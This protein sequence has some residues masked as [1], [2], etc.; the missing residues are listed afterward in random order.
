MVLNAGTQGI[1]EQPRAV[2]GGVEDRRHAA[3]RCVDLG[4]I[5]ILQVVVRGARLEHVDAVLR[6]SVHQAV[7]AAHQVLQEDPRRHAERFA[8][9]P[10]VAV[11]R[12]PA[13]IRG[14]ARGQR[15]R[16]PFDRRGRHQ[17]VQRERV[18]RLLE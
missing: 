1:S 18:V 2:D 7:A 6:G 10:Y 13:V 9:H 5:T 16:V 17:L 4:G 3:G 8:R 11:G 14:V 12:D 15:R